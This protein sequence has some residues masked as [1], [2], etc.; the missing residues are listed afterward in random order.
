MSNVAS[1]TIVENS[2]VI[3][4]MFFS[5]GSVMW[6][7]R[8]AAFAPSI[9]EDSYSSWGMDFSPARYVIMK[10][11]V[12]YQMLTSVTEKRAQ[13]GSASQDFGLKPSRTRTQ[14]RALWVGSEIHHQPR[15]DSASGMTHGIRES[16]RHTRWPR[17]GSVWMTSARVRPR[18]AF[19]STARDVKRKD[20]CTTSQ[21]VSRVRRKRKLSRPTNAGSGLVSRGG[22]GGRR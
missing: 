8:C 17:G 21:K 13:K 6:R 10:K 2:R 14:L 5:I 22:E 12:P 15:L 11:G 3:A 7:S 20:V 16:P 18:I 1:V 19:Q 4:M 9:A